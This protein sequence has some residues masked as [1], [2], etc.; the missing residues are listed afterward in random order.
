[1]KGPLVPAAGR[2]GLL[3]ACLLLQSCTGFHMGLLQTKVGF[4]STIQQQMGRPASRSFTAMSMEK[5]G[6]EG[7]AGWADRIKE[8]M[9]KEWSRVLFGVGTAVGAG[10]TAPEAT[11]AL[12]GE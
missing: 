1:M 2:A 5:E 6:S 8:G 7:A 9:G 12:K 10:Y 4:P 11:Q 3:A